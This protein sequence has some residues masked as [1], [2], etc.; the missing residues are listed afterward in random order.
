MRA[1]LSLA[2]ATS[3][4]ASLALDVSIWLLHSATKRLWCGLPK[5]HESDIVPL[6]LISLARDQWITLPAK[7]TE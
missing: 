5:L 4:L 6:N 2:H 3:L 7:R 1:W